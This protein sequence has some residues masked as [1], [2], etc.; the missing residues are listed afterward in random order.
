V[1]EKVEAL[2]FIIE[3]RRKAGDF[4]EA[5]RLG[6]RAL[7]IQKGGI[8][9]ALIR[10]GLVRD[11]LKTGDFAAALKAAEPVWEKQALSN[12]GSQA[13]VPVVNDLRVQA[14]VEIAEAQGKAGRV[15]EAL[16]TAE[17]LREPEAKVIL[18]TSLAVVR[19]RAGDRATARSILPNLEAIDFKKP[20][21]N[22]VVG[23]YSGINLWTEVARA[24]A[25]IGDTVASRASFL[26][27]VKLPAASASQGSV[28]RTQAQAGD[29]EG[30]LQTA[31]A[32][33]DEAPKSQA[34][35]SIALVQVKAGDLKGAL[36]TA[37]TIPSSSVK[38]VALARIGEAQA[39]AA[40]PATP[41]TFRDANES[42]SGRGDLLAG[43]AKLQARSGNAQEAL[44]SARAQR[45]P[46]T[47]AWALLGVAQGILARDRPLDPNEQGPTP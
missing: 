21:I 20:P 30:A 17:A 11:H 2:R 24:Q 42:A 44:G 15:K 36:R 26:R 19:A 34:L 37:R 31:E 40:D 39:Q 33:R 7:A 10:L 38:S 41:A 45:V 12:M 9:K 6:N 46:E 27:I 29:I 5:V 1:A 35:Q 22:I 32:I 18:L 3:A 16:Q 43:I 28:P 13:S 4:A 25:L 14:F 8:N 47:K 23:V